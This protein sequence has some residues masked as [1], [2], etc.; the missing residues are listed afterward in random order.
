MKATRPIF[1]RKANMH[2]R[3]LQFTRSRHAWVHDQRGAEWVLNSRTT[4]LGWNNY[5]ITG[6]WDL[7]CVAGAFV[8]PHS[9]FGFAA[10]FC[11]SFSRIHCS[12]ASSPTKLP[13]TQARR[14]WTFLLNKTNIF[15]QKSYLHP[16]ARE[17]SLVEA[18]KL[19]VYLKFG[20]ISCPQ[21]SVAFLKCCLVEP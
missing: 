11:R 21:S 10:C 1:N 2:L 12:L 5:L 16:L 14:D 17:T 9:P 20:D 6:L 8:G 13:V 7:A 15:G 4:R 3:I 19:A 18:Y